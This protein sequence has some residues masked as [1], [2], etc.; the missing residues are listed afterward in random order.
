MTINRSTL[1]RSSPH[2]RP[3][4]A[5]ALLLLALA[6]QACSRD[7]RTSIFRSLDG[8]AAPTKDFRPNP[9]P[10]PPGDQTR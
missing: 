8:G 3:V 10:T 7:T 6:A 5:A 9:S 1:N 2:A 4:L